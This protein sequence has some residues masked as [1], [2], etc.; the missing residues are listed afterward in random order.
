VIRAVVGVLLRHEKVLVAERPSSKSY[1]GYWEFPGGK[2]EAD[3][4]SQEA[5]GRELEEELGIQIVHAKPW[6]TYPYTYPDKTVFL[7]IWL[8]SD[9]IGEPH[10]KENQKIAWVT[11]SE[12]SSLRVLEGTLP[13]M[14]DIK[15]LME[16][17]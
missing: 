16:A 13:I 2:I 9:F 8:V 3:E 7:E 1:S 12:L 14:D 15:S 5:L 6:R 4:T 17:I 10:G 11:F